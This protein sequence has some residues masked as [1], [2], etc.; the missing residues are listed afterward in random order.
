MKK[1]ALN[2]DHIKET[3]DK[4][5]SGL[6]DVTNFLK[7]KECKSI[8]KFVTLRDVQLCTNS[9]FPLKSDEEFN[10]FNSLI[11]KNIS[12]IRTQLVSITLD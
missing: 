3:M 8:E 9:E 5:N 6:N 4:F 2:L 12:N 11:E 7:S 1:I 10:T